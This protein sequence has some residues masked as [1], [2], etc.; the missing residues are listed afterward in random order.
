MRFPFLL[1][2]FTVALVS[3]LPA[4]AQVVVSDPWIR[5]TVPGQMATG[6]FMKITSTTPARL[7]EAA[8]PIAGVVEI[9]EMALQNNVMRMRAVDAVELPAGREV[10]LKPGGFHVMLLDLQR[11]VKAGETIPVTLVIET[12]GRRER[13]EVRAAVRPMTAR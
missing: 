7:V 5:A 10:A 1:A 11:Q 3:A 13:V 12:A 9:H 4:A 2:A 6:A 8:C